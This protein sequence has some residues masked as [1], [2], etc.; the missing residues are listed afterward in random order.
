MPRH[1]VIV[2]GF[3]FSGIPA[4]IKKS[5][6][7]DLALIFSEKPAT[8]A[9]SFTTNK[10]KAAPVKLSMKQISAH[11]GQA[12]II[13]SGNANACTGNGG[14]KNA[15]GMARMTA[16]ALG[17]SS[18]LVYVSSTGVIGRPLP[19]EKIR[20]AIPHLTGK[21]SPFDLD[22][23]ASSIM[24]TDTFAKIYSKK[25]R[26]GT[27]TGTMAGIA[28]GA[29]M[30]CPNMATMLCFIMTDIAITPHALTSA[31]GD[32]VKESFNRISIDNDMSTNDTVMIMANGLL[33][34]KPLS[35]NSPFFKAFTDGLCDLTHKLSK[36]IVTDG[37]GATK[38]IEITITGARTETDAEIIARS[39]ANSMLV[40]TAIYGRDPN[41]GRIIAAVGYSGIQVIEK[42]IDIYLNRIKLVNKGTGTGK[43]SI[44]THQLARKN[45][46]I[47]IDLGLGR[48]SAKALTCDMTEKYVQI[49][50]HYTT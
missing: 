49:N 4:G 13:N 36:M 11:Q 44:A 28:K 23:V 47:L 15:Q 41:W 21:L 22:K 46:S 5:G 43:E 2:P 27:N 37:E 9:G 17:I 16:K 32:A 6:A 48:K 33:K 24:T 10:I 39:V 19:I 42:K 50:A 12:I 29:G 40:K 14:Y 7:L 31:L 35:K 8:T 25:I 3:S 34:N 20:K 45:I 18:S 26:I 38:F 30:I 1:S